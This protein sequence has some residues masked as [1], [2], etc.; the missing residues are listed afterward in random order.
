MYALY[1]FARITDDIADAADGSASP[2]ASLDRLRAWQER[3]ETMQRFEPNDSR[4]GQQSS[5]SDT[6]PSL[7]QFA[8]LWPAL[9][10]ATLRFEIP[11]RRLNEVIEGVEMDL[12][13]EAFEDW[14]ALKNYC[15]HVASA[16]GLACTHIWKKGNAI[17]EQAAIDCGIAFQLTNILR[18][19]AEDATVGR[20]YIPNQ[21]LDK[22]QI[23]RGAWLAGNPDGDWRA[24][25]DE[26]ADLAF[27][28]YDS[29][30]ETI[31]WLTPRSQR[32]FSLMWRTYRSLLQQVVNDK[33]HLWQ[34]TKVGLHP[35][36]KFQLA[37]THF[38][39]ALYRWS[40]PLRQK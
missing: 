30:W 28:L 34:G 35:I 39:P 21:L 12:K 6:H 19:I 2:E 29:G 24:L 32:M 1:A 14:P 37:I 36:R 7:E 20:I 23:S 22:Y 38:V 8:P 17:P 13:H 5:G 31:S 10:D 15:Y 40:P 27:D 26:V 3:L 11:V 33:Q 4:G 16:V 9:N 18:D 25:V